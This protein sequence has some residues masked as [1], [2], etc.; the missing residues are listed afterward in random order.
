MVKLIYL[1]LTAGYFISW[2]ISA[3][4]YIPSKLITALITTYKLKHSVR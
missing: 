3:Y 2:H 1:I 4:I